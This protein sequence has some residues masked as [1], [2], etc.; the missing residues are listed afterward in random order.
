MTPPMPRC[1]ARIDGAGDTALMP[2]SAPP[3][4]VACL[5]AQWCGSCRD[6]Q[7]VFERAAAE[8]AA[9]AR[10]A[11]VDIEDHDEV[12]GDAIEVEH[13]PSLLI[14]SGE[15]V[16]FFGPLEPQPGT[17]ARVVQAAL[18][19]TLAPLAPEPALSALPARVRRLAAIPLSRA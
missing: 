18:D 17:L 14:A 15:D 12:L 11:W 13:F 10:F 6:W 2:D 4:L 5:C 9:A 19:G 7:P 8:F 16:L 1:R 3:L